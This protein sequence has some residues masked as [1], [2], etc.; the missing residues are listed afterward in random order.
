MANV[1][2]RYKRFSIDGTWACIHAQ[3]IAEAD[4]A[5]EVIWEVSVDS[6][7]NRAHQHAT[8][9]ARLTGGTVELHELHELRLKPPGHALGR[10]RGGLSTKIHQLVDGRARPLVILV[11]PGQ[12]GDSLMFA[13]LMSQRRVERIGPGR[14]RTRPVRVLG[15]K[16]YSSRANRTLLRTRAIKATIAEPSDQAGHCKNRGA[17]GGRPPAFDTAAYKGRNVVERLYNRV[18]DWRGL[19]TRYDKLALAYRG[20][21]VLSAITP[22]LTD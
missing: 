20:G 22:W 2:K 13:P 16:A 18:K 19:A 21:V 11:G 1:W 9:L 8:A 10:Y 7:I 6:T 5:G 15:D 17:A 3:L 12:G 14:Q 4:A